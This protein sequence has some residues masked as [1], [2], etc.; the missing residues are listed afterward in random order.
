MNMNL[1]RR[2]LMSAF[3]YSLPSTFQEVEWISPTTAMTEYINAD[4]YLTSNSVLKFTSRRIQ[5]SNT[6]GMIFG[7]FNSTAGLRM[8]INVF[9]STG[10]IYTRYG[11]SAEKST[12]I[13]VAQNPVQDVF[14]K[15]H[16]SARFNNTD[17]S[18]TFDNASEVF[19]QDLPFYWFCANV[20]GAN[21]FPAFATI[22]SHAQV[23]ENDVIRAE[24][25]PCY[26]KSDTEIGLYDIVRRRF[27]TNAG[28][29]T[30]RKGSN[31]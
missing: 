20:N 17:H 30:F 6:N 13:L 15:G 12:N 9:G 3:D 31:V 11:S 4:Y 18:Y 22:Q 1:R 26:R 19:V 24:F 25:V 27:F 7:A 28:S 5:T 23:F 10:R 2:A 16:L 29:G 21:S 8:T 14:G